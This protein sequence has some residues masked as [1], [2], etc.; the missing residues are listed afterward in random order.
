MKIWTTVNFEA[1]HLLPNVDDKWH[2]CG[3]LHGHNYVLQIWVEG[4][5]NPKTGWVIDYWDIQ[6]KFQVIWQKLDHHYLNEI[7]GLENPTAENIVRWIWK[8]LEEDLQWQKAVPNSQSP[9]GH[10]SE[11]GS[12]CFR[13]PASDRG[14]RKWQTG[15]RRKQETENSDGGQRLEEAHR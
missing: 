6:N 9:L 12:H 4:A 11:L 7:P 15:I 2:K 3:R 13:I 14:R 8:E 5:V 10:R 1:A